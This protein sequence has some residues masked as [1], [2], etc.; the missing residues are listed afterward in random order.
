MRTEC[1]KRAVDAIFW[2]EMQEIIQPTQCMG[3][4]YRRH[5]KLIPWRATA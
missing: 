4:V 1:A 2:R 3:I 5:V